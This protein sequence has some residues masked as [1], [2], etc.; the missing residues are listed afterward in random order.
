MNAATQKEDHSQLFTDAIL[1]H[2]AEHECYNFLDGFSGYNQVSIREQD[3]DKTTFITNWGTYAYY[4]MPFGLCHA[5]ATFQR[6][7]ST[8]FQDHLRKFL[9]TIID[10]FCVFGS[11]AQHLDNLQ[12]TFK[13]C[14]ES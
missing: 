13:R 1:E 4:K 3:K 7:M 2:V 6:M 12:Q 14:M 5:P 10:H 8:I 9:E 11:H